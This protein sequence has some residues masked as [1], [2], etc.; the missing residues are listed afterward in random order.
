MVFSLYEPS[1]AAR[2]PTGSTG[3][4]RWVITLR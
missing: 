2:L 1:A 4:S 3:R